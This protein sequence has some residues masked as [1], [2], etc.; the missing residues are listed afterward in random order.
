M[1]KKRFTISIKGPSF[2]I[3]MVFMIHDVVV[4]FN[5]SNKKKSNGMWGGRFSERAADL[6]TE[7]NSSI[8]IDK[9]LAFEDI[10]GSKAHVKM[11][12]KMRIITKK[13]ETKILN[14]LKKIEKELLNGDFSFDNLLE[15]I[16]MNIESRLGEII[17]ADAGRIHT[18][19]SRNDQVVTD[20]RLWIRKAIED[21]ELELSKLQSIL[22]KKAEKNIEI[23]SP[24]YTH[25]QVA[26][27]IRFS[28]H[29]LA[30]LEM[31]GRDSE[32]FKQTKERLNE[33]PLGA[34]ALAG[35]SFPID[36]FYTAKTLGFS[37]PMRNSMDAVS[38]RDFVLEFLS[39]AAITMVHFSR[40]AEELILWGSIEFDFIS[41][42]DSLVT[43]SSIMPQKKNPD[44]A[45][46]IRAKTGRVNAA[47]LSLLTVMKGL[48]LAYAKDMQEDKETVFDTFDTLILVIKI[49]QELIENMEVKKTNM[50]EAASRG[51]ST[52]TDLADWFVRDLG[53]PFREAHALT[54]KFVEVASE[55]D[56]KLSELSLDDFKKVDPKINK[57]VFKIL[58][59]ENSI[60]SRNSFGGTASKE[61]NRQIRFWKGKLNG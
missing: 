53:M 30:Y 19:R 40:L 61:I 12:A 27:P 47:L 54:G 2:S 9:R 20:L 6:L 31:F 24:G 56:I 36:R 4:E 60:E 51:F 16:H 25:L 50:Y 39:D 18:A 32:R 8:E 17:G 11:L 45:E 57:N 44:A 48:P 38:D 26:Q 3:N 28:H 1:K 34:A 59:P 37:A 46:L 21:I 35:T 7:I 55:K 42:P 10:L 5:L 14:G 43:G 41:L 49:T 13:T 58:S 29:L 33:C 22:L 52:A 23:I 15:D